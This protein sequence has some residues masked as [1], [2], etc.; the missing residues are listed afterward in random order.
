MDA[1]AYDPMTLY[2]SKKL[3]MVA[4][5][6]VF[7]GALNWLAVGLLGRDLVTGALGKRWSRWVF[8]AVGAAALTLIWRR[9]VYLPFLGETLVPASALS[10]RTPQ[11]TNDSVTIRTLPGAKVVYWATEPAAAGSAKLLSWD[12][13]Y[14]PYENSGVAVADEKGEAVL[15]IRGPPQP[16]SVPGLFKRRL[17]PHVHFRVGAANGFLGRVQT[18]FIKDGRVEGF[19]DLI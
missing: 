4:T 7:I 5:A 14:G 17:E 12:A 6:V 3:Y 2:Y 13:A 1:T 19:A 10:P 18:L 8:V 16:Y 11:A 9:D 15:R